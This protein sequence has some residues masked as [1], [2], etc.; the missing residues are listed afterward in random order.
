MVLSIKAQNEK[1]AA[2][3]EAAKKAEEAKRDEATLATHFLIPA[4]WPS[5]LPESATFEA[6]VEWVYRN[7]RRVVK[8]EPGR[9]IRI[10]LDRARTVAPSDGALGLLEQASDQPYW[11]FKEL[12]PKVKLAKEGEN[13][14]KKRREAKKSIEELEEVLKKMLE[15]SEHA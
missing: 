15:G 6:E 1:A 10:N 2:E 9:P 5:E 14:A 8:R 13:D 7:F 3:R 4:H 11:F 12:V